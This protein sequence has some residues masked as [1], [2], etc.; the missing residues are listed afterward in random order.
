MEMIMQI[1]AYVLIYIACD[2]GRKPESQ[3]EFVS[4]QKALQIGLVIAGVSIYA[5]YSV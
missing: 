4:W 3:L 2:I 1:V 5:A